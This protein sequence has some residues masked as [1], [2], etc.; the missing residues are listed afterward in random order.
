M[1]D[2]AF[3]ALWAVGMLTASAGFTWLLGV[4]EYAHPVLHKALGWF[5]AANGAGFL[6]WA[7]KVLILG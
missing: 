7:Y 6:L 4:V 1:T 2:E 3:V 5:A